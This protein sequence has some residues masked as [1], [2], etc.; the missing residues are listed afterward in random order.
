MSRAIGGFTYRNEELY[1]ES[2]SEMQLLKERA[3]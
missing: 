2:E 1:G 3:A